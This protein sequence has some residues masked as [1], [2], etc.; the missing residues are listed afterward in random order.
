MYDCVGVGADVVTI[1][2]AM[3]P[4][5]RARRKVYMIDWFYEMIVL[6]GLPIFVV[7]FYYEISL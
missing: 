5:R 3:V 2:A 1:S 6:I 4:R 7:D